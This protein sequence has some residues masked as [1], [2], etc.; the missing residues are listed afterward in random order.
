[1][2]KNWSKKELT[3]QIV[4]A[5]VFLLSLGLLIYFGRVNGQYEAMAKQKDNQI[6]EVKQAI[7]NKQRTL[8]QQAYNKALN[9]GNSEVKLNI[10]QVRATDEVNSKV[11][12]LFAILL[13]FKNSKEYNSSGNKAKEYVT[14]NVLQNKD[15][16]GSDLDHGTHFVDASG[17]QFSYISSKTSVGILK[18]NKLPVMIRAEFTSWYSGQNHAITQNIYM[19]TY[20]YSLGK[21]TELKQVNNLFRGNANNDMY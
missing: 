21:F 18:D 15:I 3:I 9:S 11:S 19:A 16:F 4:I 12:D 2:F 8:N 13:T 17:L 7:I 6:D 14:K 1:M 20:D 10:K 5:L